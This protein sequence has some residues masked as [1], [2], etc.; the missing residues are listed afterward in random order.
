MRHAAIALIA[1]L[2]IALPAF[3]ETLGDGGIAIDQEQLLKADA[4][5]DG[6]VT[7]AEF[8]AW[9]KADL[10]RLVA[11][12]ERH[13]AIMLKVLD[14]PDVKRLHVRESARLSERF[15]ERLDADRDG[16]PS[17]EE[18]KAYARLIALPPELEPELEM[19]ATATFESRARFGAEELRKMEEFRETL[20]EDEAYISSDGGVGSGSDRRWLKSLEDGYMKAWGEMARDGV[21]QIR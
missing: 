15:V 7:E 9:L 2:G 12:S 8:K 20:G 5:H 4:S 6:Q 21:V 3:A 17:P 11:T 1:S 13:W 10:E 18:L 16:R 14:G 19:T